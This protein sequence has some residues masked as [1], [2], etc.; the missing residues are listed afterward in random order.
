M[1][2]NKILLH[3]NQFTRM[4]KYITNLNQKYDHDKLT[5]TLSVKLTHLE[6][7]LAE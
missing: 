7:Q 3:H 4:A 2:Q 6:V 5:G 1:E